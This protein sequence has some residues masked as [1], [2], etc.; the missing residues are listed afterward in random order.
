MV[1]LMVERRRHLHYFSIQNY[2]YAYSV[3]TKIVRSLHAWAYTNRK[4]KR[5]TLSN[6]QTRFEDF[7]INFSL[8][9]YFVYQFIDFTFFSDD[10]SLRAIFSK[11][12]FYLFFFFL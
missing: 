12:A 11:I 4:R 8:G 1:N 3:T 2:D 7:L 6:K 5:K 10:P 9:I